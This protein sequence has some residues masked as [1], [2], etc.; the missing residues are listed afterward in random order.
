MTKEILRIL[1]LLH[2]SLSGFYAL[3]ILLKKSSLTPANLLPIILIPFFGPLSAL[4]AE[5]TN[6]YL[7]DNAETIA[8]QFQAIGEDTYWKSLREP[9]SVENI[10][11][12]EEALI[13]NDRMTRKQI[14]F[15]TLLEDPLKNIDILLLAR[16]NNDM[17]TAHYANTTIAKIQRDFQLQIQKLSVEI[18]KDPKNLSLLEK[19]ITAL[20]NFIDSGLSEAFL[21]KKQRITL[22]ELIDR[23]LALSGFDKSYVNLKINNCI[24]LG[25]INEAIKAN[26]MLQ[27]SHPQDEKTWINA[28][29]ISVASRDPVRL[30]QTVEEIKLHDI[31]WSAEGKEQVA[32]WMGDSR[33]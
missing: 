3:I 13:I 30:D 22:S 12:L 2:F 10:V 24:E 15:D 9:E 25:E 32:L 29:R 7:K 14:V 26:R 23:R 4:A 31:V 5:M 18:E 28:L 21:L 33:E 11:P 6:R 17:D 1:F 27:E 8:G 16:E 20:S 19:Y